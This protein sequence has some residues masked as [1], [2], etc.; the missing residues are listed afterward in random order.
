MGSDTLATRA[1]LSAGTYYAG[2]R[3]MDGTCTLV[4]CEPDRGTE[5]ELMDLRSADEQRMTPLRWGSTASFYQAFATTYRLLLDAAAGYP[6][7]VIHGCAAALTETL[8]SV[9]ADGWQLRRAALRQMVARLDLRA[10]LARAASD[11]IY[12]E[13]V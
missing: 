6:Q 13:D 12:P 5:T 2:R 9:P 7:D 3:A 4:R 11:G 1:E 10:A 8:M